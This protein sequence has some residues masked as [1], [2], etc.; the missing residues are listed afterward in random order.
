MRDSALSQRHGEQG[1]APM[2]LA[3]ASWG[4]G[5]L[6]CKG[7]GPVSQRCVRSS[8][9]GHLHSMCSLIT[10]PRKQQHRVSDQTTRSWMGACGEWPSDQQACWWW[11]NA[12]CVISIRLPLQRCDCNAQQRQCSGNSA[13][14]IRVHGNIL[15]AS[16]MVQA[17]CGGVG[18]VLWWRKQRSCGAS[19]DDQLVVSRRNSN[20][21]F[22]W[23]LSPAII[24]VHRPER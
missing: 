4:S 2:L 17:C 13:A 11:W 6:S 10:W 1:D 9:N 24:I 19:G 12:L 18:A 21:K 15:P 14:R 20:F 5:K 3:S 22:Q 8:G 16:L 7:A 23:L